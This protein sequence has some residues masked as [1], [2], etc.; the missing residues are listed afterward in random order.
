MPTLHI[1]RAP[2]PWRPSRLTECG[3]L[4]KDGEVV[5][6][7]KN[8]PNLFVTEMVCK[9]CEDRT[10][11]RLRETPIE[12]EM[13]WTRGNQKHDK[14]MFFELQALGELVRRYPEEFER[15]VAALQVEQGLQKVGVP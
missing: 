1:L 14:F 4:A 9:T 2:L 13:A 10:R 15:L 8:L 12:R 11:Y 3:R 6:F 7:D 5:P